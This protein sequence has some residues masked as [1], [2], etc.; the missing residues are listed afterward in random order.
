M[1]AVPATGDL[2]AAHVSTRDILEHD[3]VIRRIADI[4]IANGDAARFAEKDRVRAASF[5]FPFG[6]EYFVAVDYAGAEDAHAFDAIAY[7]QGAVP[8][9][10]KL[11]LG[12]VLG[13]SEVV[14]PLRIGTA[15]KGRAG[16]ELDGHVA[17]EVNSRGQIPAGR[18]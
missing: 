7:Q 8:A 13:R 16:V 3:R 10:G 17:L 5:L 11:C 4:Q 14:V 18:K 6:V 9:R 1:H 12:H 15:N 2:Y